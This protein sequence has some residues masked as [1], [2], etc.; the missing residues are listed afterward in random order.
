VTSAVFPVVLPVVLALVVFGLGPALTVAHVARVLAVPRA[1]LV[2]LAC[3]VMLLPAM[4][5]VWS[6]VCGSSPTSPSG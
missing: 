5:F 6:W 3:Q 1:V 4:C 2:A